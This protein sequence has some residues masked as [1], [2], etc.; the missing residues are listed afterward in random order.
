MKDFIKG[1]V[2]VEKGD[3]TLLKVDAIVNAANS[4]LLGGG[5]VDGAIHR[6]GGPEILNACRE[7]RD[8]Q[9]PQGLMAGQVAATS[10]G[11]LSA[12]YVLHAVG[13]VWQ[14]GH[15]NEAS[16][17]R[18]T[19]INTLLLAQQ[20]G[21]TSIAFPAISTGVYSFPFDRS[22]SIV[23]SVLTD[24]STHRGS[25]QKIHLV[26]YSEEDYEEFLGKTNLD[27]E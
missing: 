24:F 12:R 11:N 1:F 10:A 20:L 19:Y 18:S 14:G 7:L 26:L 6:K 17:L 22:I 16:L 5:G 23:S 8:K 15:Y 25:L 21:I 4:S 27:P 9:Y 3:I 13:P 2:R